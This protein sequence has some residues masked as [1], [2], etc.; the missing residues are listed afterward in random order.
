MASLKLKIAELPVPEPVKEILLNLGITELFPPQEETIRAG[1]LEGK[2]IVLASPTASGKTLI[3]ELCGLKH[4]LEKNGK[5]IY[6][7]PLRALASEKFEEFRK[8]SSIRKADG[9]KVSVGISTGD[10]DTADT[11]LERYDIII[12]TNEKADSLLRH[13]AKWMDD[14]SLV[15]AD[16]VH[17][18]NEAER[19]P[20]LEVVLARLLQVN[21]DIQI[22]ALSATISNVDEIAAWL[23][24][25]YI[26]TEW[27]PV[28]LKEGV[29]L[30]EEIQYKDG[31]ARKIEKKTQ[32]PNHKPCLEHAEEWRSSFSFCFNK[33]KLGFSRKNH[34]PTHKRSLI[35]AHEANAGA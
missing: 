13:R 30:H 35:Q 3:A 21:P 6:L 12:T 23:K 19:G 10:F 17:L 7:S 4:V 8:Y 20:T 26:V 15:V 27:R 11:W 31:D 22:L 24:A 14:I 2:N 32:V 1:V 29:V 9:R 28:P 33:K 25:N 34:C 5:V 18:L 16:E